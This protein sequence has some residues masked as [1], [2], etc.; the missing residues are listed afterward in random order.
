MTQYG[1]EESTFTNIATICALEAEQ[2]NQ[3]N[4]VRLT[5]IAIALDEE[6]IVE[7]LSRLP[8]LQKASEFTSPF[9]HE[10]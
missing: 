10:M 4:L 1:H 2:S 5:L 6:V 3:L 9:W 8:S 7:L